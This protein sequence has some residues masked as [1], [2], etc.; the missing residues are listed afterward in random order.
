M[1]PAKGWLAG[2]D[3]SYSSRVIGFSLKSISI[4]AT[5]ILIA[6]VLALLLRHSFFGR[7]PISI[8]L[9]IL[10][11]LLVLWARLAFGM[12]SFHFAA[13]PTEGPLITSGP[14]RYIRN[15]IYA[16]VW[17]ASWTGIAVHWSLLHAFLG[18]AILAA[19]IVKI[20][21]EELLLRHKYPEYGEYAQRTARLIPFL[22]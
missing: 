19:L 17:L 10:G 12:R 13:N 15:P 9:Q 4:V 14:Y 5:A 21:C 16:A 11:L 22:L 2:V 8:T 18:L 1:A 20:F 3:F 7:G 6:C